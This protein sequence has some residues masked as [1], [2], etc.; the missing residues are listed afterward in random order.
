MHKFLE[1]YLG[2]SAL[3]RYTLEWNLLCTGNIHVRCQTAMD[4]KQH[5]HVSIR[6][7]TQKN[8]IKQIQEVILKNTIRQSSLLLK[9]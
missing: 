9:T 5:R 7:F 8:K 1:R 3:G 4:P 6:T 2:L